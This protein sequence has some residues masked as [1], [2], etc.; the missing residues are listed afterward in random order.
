MAHTAQ[1]AG[2]LP[3]VLF[4]SLLFLLLAAITPAGAGAA[5]R[6]ADPDSTL[7]T[8]RWVAVPSTTQQWD[9]L[10]DGV[11]LPTAPSSTSDYL[12]RTQNGNQGQAI[13]S[14]TNPQLVAGETVTD[15]TLWVYVSKSGDRPLSVAVFHPSGLL[16][17]TM[18]P[19]GISDSWF[20][21][22]LTVPA[23]Q[24]IIDSM[25]L[26][27]T[28]NGGTGVSTVYAAYVELVTQDP[29]PPPPPPVDPSPSDPPPSD[30]PPSDPPPVD[31]PVEEPPV[32]QPPAE[33]PPVE[34]PP[35][36]QPPVEQPPVEQPPVEQPPLEGPPMARAL[37]VVGKNLNATARGLVPVALRCAVNATRNCAG[38]MRLEE[39]VA[40]KRSSLTA[41][42]RRKVVGRARYK[43]EPGK[44]KTVNIRLDRRSFR[45]YKKLK[46]RSKLYLVTE[47]TDASGATTTTT[48]KVN[49]SVR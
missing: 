47:Q 31:P 44:S 28:D 16:G 29:P 34:Q 11:R 22:A 14:L 12:T 13:F 45:K 7:S 4:L 32:E 21:V 5:L 33:E 35:V 24:A 18:I 25:M 15:A 20:P 9:L 6:F 30:P 41:A 36:E 27:L 26:S 8:D 49:L 48:Q 37:E 42:R 38:V 40:K 1:Q 19:S 2:Q 43:I 10:N 46:K 39:P 17:Y 23:S 3:K